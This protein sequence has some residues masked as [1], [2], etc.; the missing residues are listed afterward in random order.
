VFVNLTSLTGKC[1]DDV[2][3]LQNEDY[4]PFL[5]QP[6]TVAY[7][8]HKIGN[9]KSL[10]MLVN[11]GAFNEMPDLPAKTL[12]KIIHGARKTKELPNVSRSLLPPGQQD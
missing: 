8:R 10:E 9:V 6:T 5:T 2:C 1:V 11:L 4:P 12:Q 7:S 3:I